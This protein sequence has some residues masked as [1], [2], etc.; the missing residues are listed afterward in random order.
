MNIVPAPIQE[1]INRVDRTR[2]L[3]IGIA[4]GVTALWSIYRIFWLFYVA[5][6]LNSFGVSGVSLFFPLVLWG[7]IGVATGLVSVAF[8][9][10]YS[11]QP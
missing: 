6:T 9:F 2:S 7:A 8:L 10:R 4:A 11:K 3:V 5:A 1:H